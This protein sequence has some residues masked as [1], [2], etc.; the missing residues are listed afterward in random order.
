[1]IDILI[2]VKGSISLWFWSAFPWL[3]MLSI[4]SH[5]KIGHLC[6]FSVKRSIQGLCPFLIQLCLFDIEFYEWFVYFGRWLKKLK[7]WCRNHQTQKTMKRLPS[8]I[9]FQCFP[10][11]FKL[12]RGLAQAVMKRVRNLTYV[13]AVCAFVYLSHSV[14]PPSGTSGSHRLACILFLRWYS[15]HLFIFA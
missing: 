10:R 15:G 14:W 7:K 12:L 11:K 4:F 2:D 6:V 5:E 1:M 3:V 8:Q 9:G 13:G